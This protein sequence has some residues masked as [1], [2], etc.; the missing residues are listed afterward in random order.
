MYINLINY[1]YEN[2]WLSF[3]QKC[4]II[5]ECQ[6][7][8]LFEIVV[9][10]FGYRVVSSR[11]EKTGFF[12][13]WSE[14]MNSTSK[15]LCYRILKT[16]LKIEKYISILPYNYMFNFCNFR[17]GGHRL[18]VETGIWHNESRADRLCHLCDSADKGDEL[19]TVV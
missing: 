5:V 11:N 2:K 17:C 13:E 9:L 15:G 4:L 19:Y 3:I 7:F 6:I 14:N 8:G 1:G 10:L 16:E 12:Q 18:P